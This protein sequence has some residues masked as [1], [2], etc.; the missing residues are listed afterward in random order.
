[1]SET[2]TTSS[3]VPVEPHLTAA[4][5]MSSLLLQY[6]A[7]FKVFLKSSGRTYRGLSFSFLISSS[8]RV[9]GLYLQPF[10]CSP[11]LS[12]LLIPLFTMSQA[13]PKKRSKKTKPQPPGEVA[14]ASLAPGRFGKERANLPIT[15]HDAAKILSSVFPTPYKAAIDREFWMLLDAD[16]QSPPP[17]SIPVQSHY[18]L[19]VSALVPAYN[20]AKASFPSFLPNDIRVALTGSES[21]VNEIHDAYALEVT[22]SRAKRKP[23][24]KCT[25]QF[26][27]T[28]HKVL[29]PPSLLGDEMDYRF[30]TIILYTPLS[31]T[32]A[33]MSHRVNHRYTQED[34]PD[35]IHLPSKLAASPEG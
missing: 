3:S 27:E 31:A 7:I 14:A 22:L 21:L 11:A 13:P 6:L 33:T 9:E 32:F 8:R 17:F 18:W 29:A 1:M 25:D 12:Y 16:K 28:V 19:A 20:K 15:L 35:P 30:R 24:V 5:V 2:Q 4:T 10:P 34:D 23:R 26:T